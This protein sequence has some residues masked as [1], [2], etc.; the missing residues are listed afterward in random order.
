[1]DE[2]RTQ[3]KYK[4][5]YLT[6]IGIAITFFVLLLVWL[7]YYREGFAWQTN[8]FK[9]FNWHPLLMFVGMIFLQ[10]QCKLNRTMKTDQL[11][12]VLFLALLMFRTGRNL[13]KKKLKLIH[14]SFNLL[15]TIFSIFGLI[16]A[17]DSH[18]LRTPPVPNLYTL[19]SWIGLVTVI[20]FV[21]QVR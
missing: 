4:L 21:L 12:I 3:Q 15:A 8:P 6:S 16:A 5:V 17:F 7:F 18:N 9:E 2:H 20:F 1:M 11:G 13:V 14:M 19:H 10:S